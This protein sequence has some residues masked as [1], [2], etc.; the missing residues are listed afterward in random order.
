VTQIATSLR[1]KGFERENFLGRTAH[2][3]DPAR[4]SA[5]LDFVRAGASGLDVPGV[6]IALYSG[7]R[8]VYEG[9][10]GVRKRASPAGSMRIPAS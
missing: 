9:G 6:G 4:V 2:P 1:P 3:L 7:G 8:I 5:L 10:V